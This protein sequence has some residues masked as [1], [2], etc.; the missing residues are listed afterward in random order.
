[1][2]KLQALPE[3]A[4]IT[5]PNKMFIAMAAKCGASITQEDLTRELS[6]FEPKTA[7]TDTTD[8]LSVFIAEQFKT[9]TEPQ[10]IE[11]LKT[12]GWTNEHLKP[13]FKSLQVVNVPLPPK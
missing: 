8:E 5:N 11:I 10:I 4:N 1:M 9:K 13:H 7:K 12:Q 3:F 6:V 2:A